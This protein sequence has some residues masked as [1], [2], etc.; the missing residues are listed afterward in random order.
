MYIYYEIVNKVH[1]KKHKVQKFTTVHCSKK[2]D[3]TP[4]ERRWGTN[5][6]HIDL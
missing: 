3:H 5:L 1:E 6:P 4:V 2:V